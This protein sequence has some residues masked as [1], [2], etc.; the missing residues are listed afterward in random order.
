MVNR[1]SLASILL[2]AGSALCFFFPFVTVSCAGEKVMT[3]SG[4]QLATGSAIEVPQ[5]FGPSR[6]QRTAADPFAAMAGLCAVAGVALS[7]A[8]AR[9]AALAAVSGAA[10]AVS[11]GVMAARMQDQVQH[12]TEGMG[13]ASLEAGFTLAI[14]LLAAAAAW[15]LYL[16][17]QEKRSAGASGISGAT[18]AASGAAV[19]A[20]GPEGSEERNFGFC[21]SCG[22]R[23]N[24][25][26]AFCGSCGA[27]L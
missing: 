2:F 17:T 3:L 24:D 9:L 6:T 8:G 16:V 14:S 20:P 10:G 22:A 26:S 11:L 19:P 5:P 12:A 4:R 21:A 23:R 18:S 25:A 7:L 13:Q 15:N 27:R 1:K